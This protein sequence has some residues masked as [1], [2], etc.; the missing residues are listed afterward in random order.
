MNAQKVRDLDNTEI[1]H[2]LKEM[3]EQMFRLRFQM[4]MGQTDG[5]KKVRQMRKDRARM[6]SV[7]RER[8]L[9]AGG[10]KGTK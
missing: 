2:Q 8:E 9:A 6:L 1:N 7:L 10:Q 3:D 5:L 4:G